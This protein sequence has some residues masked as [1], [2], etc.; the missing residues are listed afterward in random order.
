MSAPALAVLP[1][2]RPV[3]WS[4]EEMLL[5]AVEPAFRVDVYH[6]VP[7]DPVL[8]G[9]TFAVGWLPGPWGESLAGVERR[10]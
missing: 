10:R 4:W 2:A 7:G 9:P 6:A 3:E 8:H 1:G 5:E